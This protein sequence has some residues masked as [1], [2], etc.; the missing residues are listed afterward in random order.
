MRLAFIAH[1]NSIHTRRWIAWFAEAGHEI[2][3]VDPVGIEVEDGLPPGVR[4]ARPE[5]GA[6]GPRLLRGLGRGRRLRRLL[7]ELGPDVVHAHYL[8]RFGWQAALAGVRPL[9]MTPWGSDLLQIRRGAIRTRWWNRFALRRAD[10]VTVSSEGMRQAAIRA[11]AR[12]HRVRLI[13]HGVDT[14]R[15]SPGEPAAALVDR[16]GVRDARVVLSPRT[17]TPLYH[18]EVIIDAVARIPDA[19]LVMSAH[20]ADA[21]YVDRLRDHAERAG[22]GTRLRIV[23]EVPHAELADLYR[24]ADVIVSVPETDSFP[25]TLLEAMACGRPI[26]AS[27]LPAITPILGELDPLARELIVP[28]GDPTATATAIERALRLDADELRRLTGALR[29]HV[30]RTAQYDAN[31]AAMEHLYRQLAAAAR[32]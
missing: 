13:N 30:E 2:V 21:A 10:L 29:S 28:V 14:T 3:L 25:V 27:D 16:V 32:P 22:I 11:G 24:L 15:F 20:G 5:P 26:V 1:P 9:V 4:V 7:T 8:A 6:R 31:M 17:L 18:H 12:A 19:V 23:D